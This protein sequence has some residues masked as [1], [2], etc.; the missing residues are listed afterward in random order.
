MLFRYCFGV[1]YGYQAIIES[2]KNNFRK[3]LIGV[4]LIIVLAMFIL[5]GDSLIQLIDTVQQ[6][7]LVPLLFA[8]AAQLGKYLAQALAYGRC[9]KA[10][11]ESYGFFSSLALVFGTFF[12]NTVAPSLNLAGMSLVVDDAR[13]R[14]I[15]TGKASSAALLMQITI[16][17][18]FS[19]LL[20]V[21]FILI[22]FSSSIPAL[23]FVP[24]IVVLLLVAAM[25]VIMV[26]GYSNKLV[27]VK[28]LTPVEHAVE[29]LFGKIKKQKPKPW[30]Q[31]T[32][33]MFS[34]ASGIIA[35]N[36]RSVVQAF[37]CSICASCCEL[38]AFCC[39]SFAFGITSPLMML[40]GYIIATLFA[41]VS[42]TPQGV[43]F[44]EA[45]VALAFKT[46]G[47]TAAA[48]TAIGII[49][50]GIVFWIP[51]LIGAILIQCTKTFSGLSS[52][53]NKSD[54]VV[55]THRE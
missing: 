13:R 54:A 51:F 40:C 12:M 18:A 19:V 53:N 16:D 37:L 5:R 34:E 28:L 8:V 2:M 11:G 31:K 42:F 7:S 47:E 39:V 43:G 4:V 52:L 23:W 14:G 21:G 48:G 9:F 1:G 45:A 36:P 29:W 32:I 41:M 33:D 35:R 22:V 25:V 44:V 10:V 49:Y 50:R 46:F 15:E 24:G 20:L 55:D 6:G 30:V 17:G 27:L 38:L 3:L 26:M